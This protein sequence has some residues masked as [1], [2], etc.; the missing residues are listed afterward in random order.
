MLALSDGALRIAYGAGLLVG[1]GETGRRPQ[2]AAVTAVGRSALI[3]PFAFIGTEGDQKI[4][5]LINC[6]EARDWP[7]LAQHAAL[8]VDAKTVDAIARRHATGA[9]L[10]IALPGSAARSETV[11][12]LGAIAASK[13]PRAATYIGDILRAAVDLASYIDP[14]DL[15]IAA[16]VSPTRNPTFRKI[17]TGEAFLWPRASEVALASQYL[18]HNGVFF[19]A[20]SDDYIADRQKHTGSNGPGPDVWLFPAFDFLV[21]ARDR[22]GRF[23][24]ASLKP[25]L[26]LVVQRPFDGVYL[27]DLFLFAYRQGRMGKEWRTSLPTGSQ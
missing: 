4:A 3:A 19:G 15:P 12:D 13:H 23:Q 11:W 16:S 17:G 9:R 24:F 10:L 27:K 8:L 22:N 14:R 25:R 18:V 26:N 2:F 21:Q 6:H 20:E 1:W 7:S 5:D